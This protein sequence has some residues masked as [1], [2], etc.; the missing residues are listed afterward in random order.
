MRANASLLDGR[1]SER[2]KAAEILWPTILE[3][4][5]LKSSAF[6]PTTKATG[7]NGDPAFRRAHEI[8]K[9]EIDLYWKRATY[10]WALEAAIFVAFAAMWRITGTGGQLL[11]VAFAGIGAITALVG[12]LSARGSKFLA[13]ELGETH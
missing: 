4:P 9:F 2:G 12:Y 5:I 3:K 6:V 1:S 8:R 13:R 10:F 7:L 11:A